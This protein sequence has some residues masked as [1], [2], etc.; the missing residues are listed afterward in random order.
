VYKSAAAV[1]PAVLAAWYPGAAAVIGTASLLLRYRRAEP[2]WSPTVCQRVLA[3]VVALVMLVNN[4]GFGRNRL[5]PPLSAAGPTAPLFT[6]IFVVW[7][8]TPI[9]LSY[10]IADDA[11]FDPRRLIVGGLPY[12][13]LSGMLA[14]IY[15]AIVFGGQRL[16]ATVTGEQALAF[17]VI[18]ALIL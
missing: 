1:P 2:G 13:L 3:M 14:A 8:A 4:I 5:D 15:L 16:F 11:L 6:T 7:L 10:L 9:L 17:N 12:A 18:A